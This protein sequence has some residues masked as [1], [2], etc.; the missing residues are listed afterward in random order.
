[1]EQAIPWN[2]PRVKE[3]ATPKPTVPERKLLI[4]TTRNTFPAREHTLHLEIFR[5]RGKNLYRKQLHIIGRE[6]R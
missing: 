6:M 3:L 5:P 4:D 2:T 1:M